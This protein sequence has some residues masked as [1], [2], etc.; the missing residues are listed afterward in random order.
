MN[1]HI[2]DSTILK[3]LKK[4]D[5][6]CNNNI[7]ANLWGINDFKCPCWQLNN[8]YLNPDLFEVDHV[9]EFA[10]KKDNSIDNLQILCV[11]CHTIK[12]KNFMKNKGDV[13][14]TQ[15]DKK[16]VRETNQFIMMDDSINTY[17]FKII[18][19]QTI[20]TGNEKYNENSTDCSNDDD[21]ENIHNQLENNFDQNNRI[22]YNSIKK[23]NTF[24]ENDCYC[25]YCN[26][27][28]TDITNYK[29][30]LKTQRHKMNEKSDINARKYRLKIP[31]DL[32]CEN[33]EKI[34]ATKS[35]FSNHKKKGCKKSR[36]DKQQEF[37]LNTVNHDGLNINTTNSII[38]CES[39]N[40][41][42]QIIANMQK[43]N[44]DRELKLNDEINEYK[45]KLMKKE[46][47]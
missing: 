29:K 20:R 17:E 21:Y 40:V 32:K 42:Y 16:C 30:H 44:R 34:L 18:N 15:I 19:D 37:K 28:A 31:K 7:E 13:C 43:D 23:N 27:T 2:S 39:N 11:M 25:E 5:F 1:R 6:K 33:C 45:F 35:S 9:I 8:G 14:G 41:L 10:V 12:T 26:Y 46:K 47:Y 24:A 22:N 4:Q 36:S 38:N 3:L